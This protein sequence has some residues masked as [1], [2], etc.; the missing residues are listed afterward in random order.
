MPEADTKFDR[1]WIICDKNLKWKSPIVGRILICDDIFGESYSSE[2]FLFSLY[3]HTPQ[4][5]Y[6]THGI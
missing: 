3:Y 2:A 4:F 1:E 5:L 6:S